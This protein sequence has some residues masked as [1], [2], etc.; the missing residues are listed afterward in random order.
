M[1]MREGRRT[2]CHLGALFERRPLFPALKELGLLRGK[3]F[4]QLV[5]R[6]NCRL[7][8]KLRYTLVMSDILS[9]A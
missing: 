3:D 7:Y 9:K 1:K 5:E 2:D 4:I 8:M 6:R